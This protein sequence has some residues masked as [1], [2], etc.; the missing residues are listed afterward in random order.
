MHGSRRPEV[1]PAMSSG[2]VN[3]LR[4][5]GAALGRAPIWRPGGTS[6]ERT[7][8]PDPPGARRAGRR[9]MIAH[10]A[11]VPVEETLLPLLSGVGAG[12]LLARPGLCRTSDAH[13][14]RDMTDQCPAAS[15]HRS[16]RMARALQAPDPP[17]CATTR[18]RRSPSRRGR[19]RAPG[20]TGSP[21]STA[22][23][24]AVGD[25]PPGRRSTGSRR[26]LSRRLSPRWRSGLLLNV[27][28]L[29]PFCGR[30]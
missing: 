12:L 2:A 11:G 24:S 5:A 23:G 22:S 10:V 25:R 28:P 16:Q 18:S 3:G 19:R 14:A 29:D 15:D 20:A 13:R 27:P 6:G 17:C 9:H 21:T 7:S 4:G 1:T 30:P 26:A 8:R